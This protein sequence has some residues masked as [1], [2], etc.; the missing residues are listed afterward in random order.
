MK[1]VIYIL[2]FFNLG[3]LHSQVIGTLTLS[4]FMGYVKMHH[5]IVKQANLLLSEGEAKLLKSRGAFDPKL[6]VDYDRK[7]FK[8]IEYYD[9]LNTTFKIPT[10]YGIEFK[11]G[12]ERNTGVYLNNESIVPEDGLYS[13]GVSVSL[14]NGLIMNKRMATL[15][16]ANLYQQQSEA[17][18]QLLINEILYNSFLT[19]FQWL[20]AYKEQQLYEEFLANASVRLEGIKKAF[21]LGERPEI[22]IVEA[23][24]AYNN[25]KLNLE[26]ANLNYIKASL[27][28]SNY[29]WINEVPVEISEAIMPDTMVVSYVEEVL[30][31]ES[32][33]LADT[34]LVNH[35]KLLSLDYKYQSLEVERRLKKN[36]LLPKI[37]VQYNLLSET[38]ESIN[39]FNTSDY[40]AGVSVKF[41][42]FLR[43]ERGE[44][45]LTNYKLEALS[46]E[47]QSAEL[48]LLNKINSVKKEMY[49]YEN[50]IDITN[51]IVA[52]YTTLLKGE[53]RKFEVGESSLF[54]INSREV[55]L[56]ETKLK[57]I[58][59]ENLFLNTKAKLYNTLGV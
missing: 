18:N 43:K 26:K 32:I 39:S 21:E 48:T 44:L 41:P 46:F 47:R 35:P 7:K 5:P 19:Y 45:K 22:D 34:T 53:E 4:E 56:I 3:I 14:A 8:D 23:R 30:Q 29:L 38:P 25:R 58:E 20:K 50:Q 12:Y 15:K 28:L 49:S 54:L 33:N 24:I 9:K 52:D 6:E 31:L 17:D 2:L 37:D 13:L 36:N 51:N 10:W 16:K 57:A 42:L 59:M 40:K 11:G 1:Q 27:E 55:K